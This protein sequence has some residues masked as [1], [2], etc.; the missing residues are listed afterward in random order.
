MSLQ[1]FAMQR[2][3]MG[4]YNL[5]SIQNKLIKKQIKVNE[6]IPYIDNI[7]VNLST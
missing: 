1:A 5:T 3:E 2:L 7:C 6:K 4:N